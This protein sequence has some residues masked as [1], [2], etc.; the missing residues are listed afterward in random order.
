[1]TDTTIL[2]ARKIIT[3]N[4]NRPEATHVAVRDGRIL[5]TGTLDELAGWG[6]HTLDD[7]FADKVLM[8]GFVEGHSHLME[9]SIWKY[10]YCGYMPRIGPDGTR[11]DGLESIEA[12]VEWLKRC[13]AKM[14]DPDT[15]LVGWGF[16]PI[17][18]GGRRMVKAD[19]DAVSTTRPIVIIHS[20]FHLV[21]VNSLL[22]QRSNITAATNVDGIAKGADGEPNGELQEMAAKFMALN[23]I[24]LNYAAETAEA[25]GLRN[26]ANIAVRTGTTTATDLV[27]TLTDDILATLLSVTGTDDYPVRLVPAFHGDS[28]PPA[29]GA[30]RAVALKKKT[31]DKLKLGIVKLVTDGSIQGFT[32][33]LRW[34]GYYNG[35]A[36]GVWNVGPDRLEAVVAAYHDAG[37]QVFI[38]TN[39]DEAI[40]VA[41]DAVEA[42]TRRN[43][44]GDH[45]HT[46]QHC[47]MADAAQFRRMASLGMCANLFAN[48]LY[49]WGDQ[50]Y[51]VT[52]GPD[53]ANRMDG[54]AT[55]MSTGVPFAIH[56]DAPVTPLGPLFTA[57]CAVNRTTVSGRVLGEA[58]RISPADALRAITLGA[59]YTLKLDDEIGSVEVGKRAD[60]AVLDED[61]LGVAPEAL[62]D[63]PV[64]GTVV[65]GQAF[66]A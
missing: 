42:V 41:I 59:A 45:R 57:W 3:M 44:W 60:F 28:L 46:L 8:P 21:S 1:M 20:N 2:A 22:L 66:Q 58:E 32:G 15:P 63:V 37:C 31:T 29:E 48:H 43:P 36:N 53:R 30:A 64:W 35:A 26:F 12:V 23:T 16:D 9:G 11:Y 19:L 39:G 40:E 17:Y 38:H 13:E 62:K 10:A 33:R 34:P 7:R 54:C 18:F 27:N 6:E 49:Y 14:T 47:Q 50:H 65:G 56:S 25:Q 51:A 5:G 24:G 55:A 52:M 61:P 4:P